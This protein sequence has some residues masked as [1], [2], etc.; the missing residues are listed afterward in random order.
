MKLTI[1]NNLQPETILYEFDHPL[2]FTT[3]DSDGDLLLVYQCGEDD[4]RSENHYL[5]APFDNERLSDLTAGRM[6]VLE[7]LSQPWLWHAIGHIGN[8]NTLNPCSL[9]DLPDGVMLPHHS[10]MLWP[11]LEPLLSFRMV[12]KDI[13]KGDIP[14]VIVKQGIAAPTNAINGIAEY[15]SEVMP[16]AEKALQRMMDIRVQRITYASFDVGLKMELPKPVSENADPAKEMKRLLSAALDA[17]V[18]ADY[19]KALTAYFNTDDEAKTILDAVRDLTPPSYG[20]VSETQVGGRLVNGGRI[21]GLT[22]DARKYVLEHTGTPKE[23]PETIQTFIGR[24][25]EMDL[26][27]SSFT[28]RDIKDVEGERKCKFAEDLEDDVNR[29]RRQ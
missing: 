2:I 4:D 9:N 27:K 12:G 13:K 16:E 29:L 23:R 8:I 15:L 19:S 24:I 7:A 22:R 1:T 3:K 6:P 21:R 5:V 20:I 11:S 10:V 18:Q 25:R 28:L 17:A 14:G 26:D